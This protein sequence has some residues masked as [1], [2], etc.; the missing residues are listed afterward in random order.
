MHGDGKDSLLPAPKAERALFIFS[1]ASCLTYRVAPAEAQGES[2]GP[3]SDPLSAVESATLSS[4][5]GQA[6]GN[7]AEASPE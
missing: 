4:H 2:N 5:S 6:K 7:L 1:S 3:H